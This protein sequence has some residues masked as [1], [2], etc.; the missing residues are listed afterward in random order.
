[1]AMVELTLLEV[2]L[3]DSTVT[4]NTPFGESSNPGGGEDTGSETESAGGGGRSTLL[5]AVVGLVFLVVVALLVKRK[6]RGGRTLAG[7][8]PGET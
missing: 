6:L 5:A 1:M 2:H 8:E 7:H 3:D 4:A